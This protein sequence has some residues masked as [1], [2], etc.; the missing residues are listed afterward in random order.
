MG[1]QA[2][3]GGH[4]QYIQKKIGVMSSAQDSDK[5]ELSHASWLSR[6]EMFWCAS[7]GL[8]SINLIRPAREAD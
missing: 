4:L 1:S 8:K 3:G 5:I 6:G 7:G 2:D